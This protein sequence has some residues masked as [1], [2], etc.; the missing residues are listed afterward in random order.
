MGLMLVLPGLG[1]MR[2]RRPVGGW[3][4]VSC[5][6]NAAL[7]TRRKSHRYSGA[8]RDD[9]D[10][11]KNPAGKTRVMGTQLAANIRVEKAAERDDCPGMGLRLIRDLTGVIR[12]LASPRC[13]NLCLP[14]DIP[15]SI[16]PL[17]TAIDDV[18]PAP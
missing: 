5:T 6:G 18:S 9:N 11:A 8:A 14:W 16:P 17:R 1:T 7:L 15:M 4:A 3:C 12:D 13:N 2:P 10:P